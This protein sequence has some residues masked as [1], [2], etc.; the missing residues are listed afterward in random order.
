M[1]FLF[2]TDTISNTMKKA[3]SANLL[4][5][6]DVT[7]LEDQFTTTITVGEMTYGALRSTRARDILNRL[8]TDVWPLLQILPFDFPAAETYG[9]LK[10]TLERNGT[11]VAEPDLRIAA[12]AIACNHTLVTGN[13]RHFSHI[14]GLMVEDWIV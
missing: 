3:P 5:R 12:I 10:A 14:P 13:V 4:R 11:S 9:K 6:F 8:T 2:D 1:G 7:P